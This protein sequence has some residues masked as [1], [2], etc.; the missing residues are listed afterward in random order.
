ML[1]LTQLEQMNLLQSQKNL[2]L[3]LNLKLLEQSYLPRLQNYLLPMR[4]WTPLGP[5][6]KLL[7]QMS[8]LLL[9]N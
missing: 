3:K 6:L 4:S 9:R 8:W 1:S 7:L 2:L 5:S